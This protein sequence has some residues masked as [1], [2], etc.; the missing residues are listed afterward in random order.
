VPPRRRAPTLKTVD[1]SAKRVAELERQLKKANA[2]AE[3]AEALVEVQNKV[4]ALLDQLDQLNESS[5]DEP[6]GSR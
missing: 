1:A 6:T 3:R 5:D 2:R 4:F